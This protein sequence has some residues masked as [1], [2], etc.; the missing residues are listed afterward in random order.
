[1]SEYKKEI[2]AAAVIALIAALGIGLL[3]I[4]AFPN[5]SGSRSTS[6]TPEHS[7]KALLGYL[8]TTGTSCS[9][10]TGTCTFTIVNNST[11]S[12]QLVGCAIQVIVFSNSTYTT[13]DSVN[14]TMGGAATAGIPANSR[15]GATCTIP[16]TQLALQTSGSAAEGS[17]IVRL[18]DNMYGYPVGDEP[19]FNF[20]GTWS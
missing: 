16:T 6:T 11:A 10:S 4:T 5:P 19:T 20:E 7:P 2:G 12:L 8:G 1:M 13:V 14:G 15:V 17:F 9:L 3:A 18:G